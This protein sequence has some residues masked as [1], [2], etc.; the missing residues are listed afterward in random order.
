MLTVS[1]KWGGAGGITGLL[2]LTSADSP[3]ST[4]VCSVSRNS[5]KLETRPTFPGQRGVP[6]LS[7]ENKVHSA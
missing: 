4:G 6:L 2:S 5:Q 3:G 1:R 7:L